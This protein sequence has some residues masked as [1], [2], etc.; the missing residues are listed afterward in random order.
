MTL[1]NNISP[2]TTTP[3]KPVRKGTAFLIKQ[4]KPVVVPIVIDGLEDRLIKKV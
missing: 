3:F 4:Y 2:G 1:G